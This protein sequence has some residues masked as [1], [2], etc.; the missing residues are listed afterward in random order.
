MTILKVIALI[1]SALLIYFAVF[2]AKRISIPRSQF[3]VKNKFFSVS[4]ELRSWITPDEVGLASFEGSTNLDII[5]KCF[6]YLENNYLYVPDNDILISNS[7][8]EL[9]AKNDFWQMPILSQAFINHMGF[10]GDC[11]DGSFYLQSILEKSGATDTYVC[12][13]TVELDSGT[14]GHAWVIY[15]KNNRTYLLET[16]LGES[17]K[18]LLVLPDYYVT[19]VKF[20]SKS[21]WAVTGKSLDE[22]I[23]RPPLP[24]S[25]VQE[26]RR[27]LKG[28]KK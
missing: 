8:A 15:V 3:V 19:D 18:N 13:G 20:N 22:V 27:K 11:E 4:R 25:G 28:N 10:R 16:T 23:I 1:I 5:S 7:I 17:L 21:V 2:P 14:Y 6:N 24:V 9:R 26:L 12:I